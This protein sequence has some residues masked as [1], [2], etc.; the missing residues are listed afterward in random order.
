MYKGLERRTGEVK[1]RII[2]VLAKVKAKKIRL[3]RRELEESD[4]AA[5]H[6]AI[7][8]PKYV[9]FEN[10]FRAL[11]DLGTLLSYADNSSIIDLIQKILAE[12]HQLDLHDY[13]DRRK[14]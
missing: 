8:G 2:N 6:R 1:N 11:R 9:P 7:G 3:R 12:A 13:H 5:L 14:P 4:T 10:M